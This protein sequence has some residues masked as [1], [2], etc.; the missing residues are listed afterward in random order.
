LGPRGAGYLRN[1]F[2][3]GPIWPKFGVNSRPGFLGTLGNQ[4][5]R[6]RPFPSNSS[7]WTFGSK[8]VPSEFWGRFFGSLKGYLSLA[9]KGRR[10]L[11][12]WH[13]KPSLGIIGLG[14]IGSREEYRNHFGGV[15]KG[16]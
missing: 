12:N 13:L 4:T 15:G 10:P 11:F 3:F 6:R 9:W 5:A 14:W 16:G 1:W 7:P 2:Q 8:I